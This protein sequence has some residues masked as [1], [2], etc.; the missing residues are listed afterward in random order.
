MHHAHATVS[1]EMREVSSIA[2]GIG[3]ELRDKPS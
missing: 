3:T 1:L 2:A